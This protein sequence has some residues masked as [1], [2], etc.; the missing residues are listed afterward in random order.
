MGMYL[1]ETQN[2][3]LPTSYADKVLHLMNAGA[4]LLEK[5]PDKFIPDLIC[6]VD[7]GPFAAAAYIYDE[8]EFKD[9]NNPKDIRY[10]YTSHGI[11]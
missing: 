2:G 1:N 10:K 11:G 3:R 8:R 5:K 4:K 6:V 7:N 9:F